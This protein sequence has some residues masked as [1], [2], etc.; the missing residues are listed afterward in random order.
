MWGNYEKKKRNIQ[1]RELFFLFLKGL[2]RFFKLLFHRFLPFLRRKLSLFINLKNKNIQLCFFCVF[3]K[4]RQINNRR[5]QN[6][7]RTKIYDSLPIVAERKVPRVL[8]VCKSGWW[9]FK[10]IDIIKN[11]KKFENFSK[12]LKIKSRGTRLV[13][14]S[15]FN[16]DLDFYLKVQ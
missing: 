5:H 8:L 12:N 15:T 13:H 9:S 7:S 2:W 4:L 1:L 3:M 11:N 10:I 16:I 14:K 6:F